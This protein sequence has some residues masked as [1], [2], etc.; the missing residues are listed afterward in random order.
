MEAL[1][2]AR[3]GVDLPLGPPPRAARRDA[4]DGPEQAHQRGEVV[5]PHVH[6][7]SRA[8]R[9]QERRLR[10]PEVGPLRLERRLHEQRRADDPGRDG[11]LGGLEARPQDGVGSRADA[12]A[13]GIRLGEQFAR[14]LAVKAQRL[15][16]PHVLARGDGG[17]GH[18]HVHLRDGEVHDEID[19]RVGQHVL[20]RAPGADA[21]LLRLGP[22]ALGQQVADGHDV[23]V[24]ERRQVLEVGLADDA[25]ADDADSETPAHATNPPSRRNAKL[26]A[27]SSNTSPGA[28]SY[29]ITA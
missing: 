5:R 27:M 29:S 4:G 20:A 19:V 2:R 12:H 13:R 28:L 8:L 21:V 1:P 11:A 9:E 18:L 7:G 17:P 6:Q 23:D 24:G 14:G 10:M 22:G 16:G 26:A 15:L 3:A 25:G